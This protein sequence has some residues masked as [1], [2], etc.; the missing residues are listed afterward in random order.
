MYFWPRFSSSSARG[1]HVFFIVLCAQCWLDGGF[2]RE[3]W[4]IQKW[5]RT[6]MNKKKQD[7]TCGWA[8]MRGIELQIFA[9]T[10]WF[11]FLWSN[12]LSSYDCGEW[13]CAFRRHSLIRSV[14]VFEAMFIS[15][16]NAIDAW[17]IYSFVHSPARIL[18]SSSTWKIMENMDNNRFDSMAFHQRGNTRCC[19]FITSG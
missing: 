5:K 19:S 12:S 18:R 16:S 3:H 6:C 15:F 17:W 8:R 4:A 1:R 13:L 7:T 2:V 11:S 14:F 9:V 10:I